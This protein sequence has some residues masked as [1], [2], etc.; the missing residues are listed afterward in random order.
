M[1]GVVLFYPTAHGLHPFE[2][3]RAAISRVA[4]W[5]VR[6]LPGENGGLVF[7]ESPSYGVLARE[8]LADVNLVDLE[9]LWI[10]IEFVTR[11]SLKPGNISIHAAEV[12]PVVY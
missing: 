1:I 4:S 2:E 5:F 8:D 6:K 11:I 7:V 10:A 12:G 3:N 9:N